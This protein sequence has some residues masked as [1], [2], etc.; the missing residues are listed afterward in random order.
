[1]LTPP[2][3]DLT[4]VS[5]AGSIVSNVY[6]YSKWLKSLLSTSGPISKAGH[7][8]LR[9]PRI[10]EDGGDLPTPFTGPQAYAFGWSTGVYQGYEFFEHSGGMIA[11][12][13]DLI[14]F[15]AL[16]YGLIAFANTAVTSNF[17]EQALLWHL[18][19]EHL[20]IPQEKRFDWNKK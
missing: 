6:D 17:L 16:N 8:A 11:F 10:F 13:T 15:S 9:T 1:M 3:M 5:G 4:C 2:L 12:A 19:D 20:N 7:K 14:F 18:V